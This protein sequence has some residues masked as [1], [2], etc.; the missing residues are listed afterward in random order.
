[1]SVCPKGKDIY[2]LSEVTICSGT[3]NV[4]E[5]TICRGN[6]KVNEITIL[7]GAEKVFNIHFY[8]KKVI[9]KYTNMY[10]DIYA[11]HFHIKIIHNILGRTS[12]N[13]F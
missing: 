13:M 9:Y 5:I 3:D 2:S 11:V 6:D 12:P 7:G 8:N 10:Q 4:L 1:M